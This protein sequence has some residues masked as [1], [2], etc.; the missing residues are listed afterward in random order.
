MTSVIPGNSKSQF[1]IA[2]QST[3]QAGSTFKS[4]VLAAAIEKGIDPDSTYYPSAP[5]TCTTGPWCVR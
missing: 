4:F 5:F 1:N 3:R 2:A